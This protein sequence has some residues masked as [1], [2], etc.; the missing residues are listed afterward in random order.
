M[1]QQLNERIYTLARETV[2]IN[3]ETGKMGV[4]LYFFMLADSLKSKIYQQWAEKLLDEIYA[5]LSQNISVRTIPDLLQVGIGINFLFNRKYVKGNINQALRELDVVLFQR[6]TVS[7]NPQVL[8]YET[9]GFLYILYYLYLRL[10][11]QKP[12][13]DNRFLTGEL[14]IKALNEVYT[15]INSSFYDEPDLFSLDYNLPPF[16][17]VISK[18]HSL[19]F[20]NYRINEVIKEMAGLIQSRIPALHANR[21]YLLWGLVH[22]KRVTGYEFWNEQIDMIYHSISIPKIIEQELRNKQVFIKNGVA[23][24]Y[25]LLAALEKIGCK[26]PYNIEILRK[27]INDSYPQQ[28]LIFAYGMS[29]LL[30]VDHLINKR[31]NTL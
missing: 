3:I 1:N 4:C 18:I 27:R 20:Y 7:K 5:Q 22:L 26:I 2:D 10:E 9:P 11:K 17:F 30:W 8:T 13:S 24:I 23:G 28:S 21:L 14:T 25:L 29:G 19:N 12:N 16:L 15:S 6:M 31:I